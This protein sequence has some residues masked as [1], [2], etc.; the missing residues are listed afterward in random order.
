MIALHST[1]HNCSIPLLSYPLACDLMV[2]PIRKPPHRTVYFPE[3]HRSIGVVDDSIFKLLVEVS[4]IQKDVWIPIPSVEVSFDWFHRLYNPLQLSIPRQ[5]DKCCVCAGPTRIDGEAS[6]GEYLVM[7]FADF[8]VWKR[9]SSLLYKHDIIYIYMQ[10]PLL[11]R[12]K[13]N[14]GPYRRW[15]TS[16]DENSRRWGWMAEKKEHYQNYYQAWK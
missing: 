15:R 8:S 7:L 14:H 2:N 11:G 1:I 4:I 10:K 16:R 3:L 5:D 6:R 13:E 9:V 12:G